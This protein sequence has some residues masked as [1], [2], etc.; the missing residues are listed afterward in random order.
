MWF[1][2][3]NAY[4]VEVMITSII[5]KLELINFGQMTTSIIQFESCD[6][7]LLVTSWT[8]ITTS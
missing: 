3:S 5:E 8:K 1:F 4:K 6:E 7:I 2:W